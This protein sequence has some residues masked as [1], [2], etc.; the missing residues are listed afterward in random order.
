VAGTVQFPLH[1]PV[2]EAEFV[3]QLR[4]YVGLVRGAHA[5]TWHEIRRRETEDSVD[6][7]QLFH[8]AQL[9]EIFALS[10]EALQILAVKLTVDCMRYL[11]PK[12]RL[13][14]EQFGC[15]MQ[16]VIRPRWP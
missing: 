7:H 3:L 11:K 12:K 14:S 5:N 15:V 1:L 6:V 2:A 13:S 10:T 8:N 16:A 9:S 4:K